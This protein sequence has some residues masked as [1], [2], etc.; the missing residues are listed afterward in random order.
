M[1]YAV[2]CKRYPRAPLFL[3][4]YFHRAH[5]V[6]SIFSSAQSVI[7]HH[8]FFISVPKAH[9]LSQFLPVDAC[10]F[11]HW[12]VPSTCPPTV[13]SSDG[14]A[15]S[16]SLSHSSGVWHLAVQ[17]WMAAI[18][19]LSAVLTRRCRLRDLRSL[20]W[21]ETMREVK[22][23]P[24]PPGCTSCCV[25]YWQKVMLG[26]CDLPDMSVTSTWIAPRRWVMASRREASVIEAM[27]YGL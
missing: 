12:F 14:A 4:I 9:L 26:N 15:V 27:V 6:H 11:L 21:G 19:S 13:P 5:I 8:M 2:L 25:S 3:G 23:W 1:C 10:S 18:S 17:A 24:Q 20:N 7:S 22:A 16:L